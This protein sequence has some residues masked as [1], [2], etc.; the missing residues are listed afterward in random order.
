M[1]L[2]SPKKKSY[3]HAATSDDDLKT[4]DVPPDQ[5]AHLVAE[6]LGLYP[7]ED[8]HHWDDH[9]YDFGEV[10]STIVENF[11]PGGKDNPEVVTYPRL[12]YY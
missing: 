10:L 9:N 2:A 11:G 1:A 8:F 3:A 7:L 5:L 12:S 4:D 6:A